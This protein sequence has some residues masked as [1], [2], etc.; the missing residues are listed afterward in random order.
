MG[1]LDWVQVSGME[2]EEANYL[3][4]VRLRGEYLQLAGIWNGP[5]P[6]LSRILGGRMARAHWRFYST[7]PTVVRMETLRHSEPPKH[8]FRQCD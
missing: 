8:P 3:N 1:T 2:E 7:V 5:D 6:V 4:P